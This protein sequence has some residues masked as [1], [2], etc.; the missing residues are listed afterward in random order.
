MEGLVARMAAGWAVACVEVAATAVGV[1]VAVTAEA[2][3]GPMEAVGMGLVK[4]AVEKAEKAVAVLVMAMAA[5]TA[6]A[7]AVA[8]GEGMKA[9]VTAERMEGAMG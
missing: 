2:M 8:S 1:M 6:V 9:T 3:V 7:R 5:T 4:E